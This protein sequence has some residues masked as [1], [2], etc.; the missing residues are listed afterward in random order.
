MIGTD[1]APLDLTLETGFASGAEAPASFFC[2]VLAGSAPPASRARL[3]AMEGGSEE[4]SGC[5]EGGIAD[6][7]VGGPVTGAATGITGAATGAAGMGGGGGFTDGGSA[8]WPLCRLLPGRP[9]VTGRGADGGLAEA[10]SSALAS[11]VTML[12]G[13]GPSGA[14]LDAG[15]GGIGSEG[16]GL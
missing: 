11:G 1:Q 8:A 3:A 14:I 15:F 13:R 4:K 7:V 10:R 16:A 6:G 5:V 12:G 2:V 9:F